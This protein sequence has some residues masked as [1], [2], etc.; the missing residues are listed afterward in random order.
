[1]GYFGKSSRKND[2]GPVGVDKSIYVSDSRI[3][4]SG[5]AWK[6][7]TLWIRQEYLTKLKAIAHFENKTTQLL[8]DQALEEYVSRRWDNSRAMKRLVKQA[9]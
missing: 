1:M 2:D 6:R 7:K 5:Q 3:D 9:D 8:M 4:K